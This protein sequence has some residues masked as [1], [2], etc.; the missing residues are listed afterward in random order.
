M[1]EL[2]FPPRVY[3]S[4][5]GHGFDF[6]GKTEFR[7]ERNSSEFR[8]KIL[9]EV[10]HIAACLPAGPEAPCVH[11]APIVLPLTTAVA[12]VHDR[13][14]RGGGGGGAQ[15]AHQPRCLSF[16]FA[17]FPNGGETPNMVAG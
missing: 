6:E 15:R 9:S 13:R 11:T 5:V 17:V 4:F 2:P 1:T 3:S 10:K 8:P 7:W 14:R 12:S 16:S